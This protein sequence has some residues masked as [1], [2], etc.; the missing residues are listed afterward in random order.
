METSKY[1]GHW[2]ACTNVC[3]FTCA[4][5]LTASLSIVHLC[6]APPHLC[7]AYAQ[8]DFVVR[9]SS[10]VNMSPAQKILNNHMKPIRCVSVRECCLLPV[11]RCPAHSMS[12]HNHLRAGC[13][14]KICLQ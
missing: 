13:S 14:W 10:R 1:V 4:S 3:T 8:S 2:G 11:L 5:G 7:S 12:D 9:A 6:A